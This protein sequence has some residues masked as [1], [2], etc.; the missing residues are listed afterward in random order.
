MG[1]PE[2]SW[3]GDHPTH[4]EQTN[5]AYKAQAWELQDSS[6]FLQ[7][8][9]ELP[10]T[11]LNSTAGATS[12]GEE[13]TSVNSLNDFIYTADQQQEEVNTGGNLGRVKAQSC[14][15]GLPTTGLCCTQRDMQEILELKK[16][17]RI[18]AAS[19]SKGAHSNVFLIKTVLLTRRFQGWGHSEVTVF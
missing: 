5:S 19:P 18:G 13:K 4:L 12:K 16:E 9:T 2:L 14:N 11:P 15:P 6:S 3:E 17:L 8:L 10:Q 1:S 7:L